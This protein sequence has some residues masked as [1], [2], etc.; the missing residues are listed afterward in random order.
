M[1]PRTTSPADGLAAGD[2]LLRPTLLVR[3]HL[4]HDCIQI[5][6]RR[7]LPRREPPEL[8]DLRRY[9]RLRQVHLGGVIDE[10]VPVDV[11]VDIS[12]LEGITS[13]MVDVGHPQLDEWFLPDGG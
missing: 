6:R 10:P 9:H 13:Q 5:E 8:F 3:L 12:P 4:S 11:R 1:S 2:D 7:P